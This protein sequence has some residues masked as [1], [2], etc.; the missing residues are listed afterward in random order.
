MAKRDSVQKRLEK[1]RPPRVQL[2]YEVEIGDAIEQKEIPFVVGVLGDFTGQ[3]AP[4][5]PQPRLKD[6]KFINVDLD[7]FDEVMAGMAPRVSYRVKNRL[8][9]E[10]GEFAVDLRFNKLDDFRPESVVQQVEP[11]RKL[12]EARSKLADLRNKLAGNEKLED[13]LAEVLGNTERLQQ[14]G[15]E[16]GQGKE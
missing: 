5:K 7:S 9:P 13:L 10:G 14:L 2:T 1:V 6:R 12:L 11:L 3:P 4:D 16:A 15:R 8:S